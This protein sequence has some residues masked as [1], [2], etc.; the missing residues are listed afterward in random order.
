M[1]PSEV[2]N[3]LYREAHG[4]E[5]DPVPLTILLNSH[6]QFFNLIISEY[7]I[8]TIVE[9]LRDEGDDRH[10]NDIYAIAGCM[11]ELYAQSFRCAIARISNPFTGKLSKSKEK[12]LKANHPEQFEDWKTEG[13]QMENSLRSP[14]AKERAKVALEKMRKELEKKKKGK[15]KK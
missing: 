14:A 9:Y 8:S 13:E 11:P 15:D 3:K 4:Q 7:V 12:W 2:L 10:F 5:D 1:N 6:P